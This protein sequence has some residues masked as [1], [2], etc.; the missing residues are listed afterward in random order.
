MPQ[1]TPQTLPTNVQGE[2]FL[3][4]SLAPF[5][6]VDL[7]CPWSPTIVATC[8]AGAFGFG[9]SAATANTDHVRRL[10]RLC[11]DHQAM[12]ILNSNE[13]GVQ[14]KTRS[15]RPVTFHLHQNTFRTVVSSRRALPVQCSFRAIGSDLQVC[16]VSSGFCA[17]LI[18][19]RSD[20]CSCW[21]P[22]QFWVH[23]PK[24]APQLRVYSVL[25]EKRAL[26]LHY[27]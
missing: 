21:M 19:N 13:V 10:G 24:D 22:E 1:T 7:E 23:S 20:S 4:L 14:T 9:T 12:A 5:W 16:L 17:R 2:L 3:C 27:S 6:E 11:I 25:S 18:T 26:G 15:F 8:A